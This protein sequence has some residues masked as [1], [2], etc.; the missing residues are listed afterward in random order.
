[1]IDRATRKFYAK[2]LKTR[3]ATETR[4]AVMKMLNE[5][6]ATQTIKEMSMD[7]ASEF[8]S[9]EM[10][11]MLQGLGPRDQDGYETNQDGV[12]THVKPP[13]RESR[14]DISDLDSK[15]GYF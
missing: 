8:L 7:S 4:D 5:A 11:T 3:T 15:N 1:M 6:Q 2:P 10:R 14:Q 12:V 9:A 13:G